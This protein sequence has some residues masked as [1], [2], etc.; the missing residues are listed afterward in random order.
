MK[1]ASVFPILRYFHMNLQI[2][3]SSENTWETFYNYEVINNLHHN[4]KSLI[5]SVQTKCNEILQEYKILWQ[6][7]N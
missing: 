1:I 6:E 5:D 4:D 3:N 7:T 2:I